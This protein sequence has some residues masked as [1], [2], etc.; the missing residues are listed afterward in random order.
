MRPRLGRASRILSMAVSE[1][2]RSA[3]LRALLA[4]ELKHRKARGEQPTEAEYYPL[5]PES[6]A[7]IRSVFE[8]LAAHETDV[9]NTLAYQLGADGALGTIDYHPTRNGD[10][11]YGGSQGILARGSSARRTPIP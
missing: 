5:F 9:Q 8:K 7:V 6:K 2:E 3:I 10:R 1:P 11:R 4:V